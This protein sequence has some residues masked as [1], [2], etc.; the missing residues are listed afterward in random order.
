[1]TGYASARVMLR[2]S[3]QKKKRHN[4]FLAISANRDYGSQQP[5]QL[6]S[7]ANFNMSTQEVKD[8]STRSHQEQIFF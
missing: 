1:M 3:L 4:I 8:Q 2:S 5:E 7:K 6:K